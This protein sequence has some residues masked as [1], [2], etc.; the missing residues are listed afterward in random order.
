MGV[1]E[2]SPGWGEYLDWLNSIVTEDEIIS[3]ALTESPL[4]HPTWLFK[5]AT[6]KE[7]GGYRD[8]EFPEDYELFLRL[9]VSGCRFGKVPLTCLGWR[10]HPRRLTRISKRCSS[11]AFLRLK[12]RYLPDIL[13][14]GRMPNITGKRLLIRGA[15]K[16]GRILAAALTKAGL[17]PTSFIDPVRV[18]EIFG[19]IPVVAP[20]EIKSE[21]ALILAAVRFKD[22]RTEVKAEFDEAG[23]IF[24]RDYLWL[25]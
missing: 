9:L 19:G 14:S 21:G 23:L 2:I 16:T 13:K 15:G 18:G 17:V 11:D 1:G 5:T 6:I 12:A 20:G 22:I 4:P 3:E 24:G 8:G 7:A 10:D 25:Y